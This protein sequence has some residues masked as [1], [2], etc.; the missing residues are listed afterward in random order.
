MAIV[1]VGARLGAAPPTTAPST[2]P[3]TGPTTAPAPAAHVVK[4]GSLSFEIQTEGVFQP[5]EPY[6]V[7]SIFKVYAGPLTITSIASNAARLKK[8]DALLELEPTQYKWALT[9]AEN[10]LA[11]ATANRDKSEADLNLGKAADALA[12]RIAEDGVKN[13]EA[14]QK[15]FEST[16]GPQMLLQAELM[17]KNSQ[18]SLDD[19]NDELDQLRK[20]YKSEELTSATADIVVKRAFR[21]FENAKIFLKMA[22]QRREKTKEND[23]QIAKQKMADAMLL[24]KQGLESLKVAQQQSSVMRQSGA[25]AARLAYEQATRK[26]ADLKEDASGLSFKAPHDGVVAYTPVAEATA[27]GGEPKPLKTGDKIQAGQVVMR[28]YTPGKMRMPLNLTETQAFWVDASAKAKVTP[29]AF[30][31]LSYDASCSAPEPGAKP[32]GAMGFQLPLEL[33]DV[34][35]RILPG[36]KATVH[37]DAGRVENVLLV[38]LPM[39]KDGKVS[40]RGKDGKT[41]SRQLALG[42][43]DGQQVEVREGLSEGDEVLPPVKK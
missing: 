13:A 10:E 15:W 39:I 37:I 19:Q 11:A 33:P 9:A 42:K 3:S 27:P 8:G 26:L 17:V 7:K 18:H 6:E 31:Q 20:M 43:S 35:H 28:L 22:E 36:M 14:A 40:V 38:P 16:D 21:Q 2:T 1:T 32:P 23:F 25:T 34:D 5:V 12:M 41:E 30:P 4:R 29:A 24:A